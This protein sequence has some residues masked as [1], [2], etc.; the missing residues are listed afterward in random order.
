MS[1]RSYLVPIAVLAFMAT[2]I[3]ISSASTALQD[4][5]PIVISGDGDLTRENGVVSGRGLRQDPYVIEGWYISCGNGTGISIE[6]TDDHLVIRDV[7]LRS[8]GLDA[9]AGVV[10][11]RLSNCTIDNLSIDGMRYG[12]RA[13]SVDSLSI[14]SVVIGNCTYGMTGYWCYGTMVRG[15]RVYD[16]SVG[17]TLGSGED[18]VV[19][20]CVVEAGTGIILGEYSYRNSKSFM[21]LNTTV[22]G[23]FRSIDLRNTDDALVEGCTV[24]NPRWENLRLFYTHGTVVR[25]NVLDLG[26]IMVE[27]YPQ[28]PNI[29]GSN[30]VG[31]LPIRYLKGVKDAVVDAPSGQMVLVDCENVTVANQSFEGALNPIRMHWCNNITV[32]NGTMTDAYRGLVLYDCSDF[33]L[34]GIRMNSSGTERRLVQGISIVR[35]AG[36]IE[37]CLVGGGY[38]EGLGVYG[39]AS[40][41]I[42]NSTIRDFESVGVRLV[43]ERW[44]WDVYG[45]GILYMDRCAVVGNAVGI[46]SDRWRISVSRSTFDDNSGTAID[47]LSSDEVVVTGCVFRNNGVSISVDS[48]VMG[49][50]RDNVLSGHSGIGI[51]VI[52]S[53]VPV[54]DNNITGLDA[55]I[56]VD[57]TMEP[58]IDGN[59]VTGAHGPGIEVRSSSGGG[60]SRCEVFGCTVGVM[61]NGSQDMTVDR[62]TVVGGG[63]GFVFGGASNVT[64]WNCTARW[65]VGEGIVVR[66]ST[67]LLFHHNNLVGNNMDRSTG[68]RYGPQALDVDGG[69]NQWDDG[70]E[71]N[72]WTDMR[73]RYPDARVL[74]GRTWNMSYEVPDDGEDRYPLNRFR[75]FMPPTVDAGEDRTV[76]QGTTV[77]L[78][79][80]GTTDNVRPWY[81]VWSVWYRSENYTMAGAV[82]SFTFNVPGR[83]MITLR[84]WD[85]ARNEGRDNV[86]ITVLD[87]EHPIAD[88]GNGIKV[89][90]GQDFYLVGSRSTDNVGIVSYRWTVDPD[91]AHIVLEGEVVVL[92]LDSYGSHLVVLEVADAA[93][94]RDS[95]SITVRVVDTSPPYADAG[96]DIHAAMG[97]MVTFNGSR[98]WDNTGITEWLWTVKTEQ[99]TVVLTGVAPTHYFDLPG[100]FRVFLRVSDADGNMAYDGLTVI[101]VDPEPPV[102]DAG[103]DLVVGNGEEVLLDGGA[104]RDN[105]RIQSYLWEV[106]NGTWTVH[107]EGLRVPMVFE[108]VGLYRVTLRVTDLDGNWDE[109]ILNVTVHDISPPVARAGRD[110]KVPQGTLV[111]LD[112]SSSTDNV[113][114]AI[115]NWTVFTGHDVIVLDG[116]VVS[117]VF[118]TPG[119]FHATLQVTDVNELTDSDR[120]TIDVMDTE[121]PHANAGE[122]AMA[123]LRT[124]VTLDGRLSTDNGVIADYQWK[125][126]YMGDERVFHGAVVRF[127]FDELGEYDIELRVTD[128]DGN[129]D[130]DDLV[131]R[132]L[133][134]ELSVYIGPFKDLNTD[135]VS[136]V[137]VSVILNG[138]TYLGITDGTGWMFVQVPTGE[139]GPHVDVNASKDGYYPLSFR[140]RLDRWGAPLGEVPPMER[141]PEPDPERNGSTDI[142]TIVIVLV[143]ALTVVSC[144]SLRLKARS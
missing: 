48:S 134:S 69:G 104:S 107:R 84:V 1:V 24:R 37:D 87:T 112:G 102:A 126:V 101:V 75:D 29:D 35:G 52:A 33:V 140:M 113:G 129:G 28:N 103:E 116:L 131:V 141:V 8:T 59:I 89:K 77:R 106:S 71:G 96:P 17:M 51:E 23:D 105:Y 5:D 133:P 31:G 40:I 130:S 56:L 26:G 36:R 90:P 137:H 9:D 19:R 74:N 58:E 13:Y 16:C 79:G 85:E 123:V 127:A 25:N 86:W 43:P 92:S 39:Q 94:N 73:K 53:K 144:A 2:V 118:G 32:V 110:V 30:T 14:E 114:I 124:T 81:F 10:L 49:L 76:G 64:M 122:D 47:C 138:T 27:G 142:L 54:V 82:S 125:F 128:S 63:H 21:L 95:D 41:E 18:L 55:A 44:D 139:L 57:R 93:G 98:C 42:S 22:K 143:L 117:Y 60:V 72:Y 100:V 108:G 11:T 6:G 99:Q 109:D 78:D 132:V 97:T 46:Y 67:G 66:G 38:S 115:A 119:A 34:S 135:P 80:S 20:D 15:V 111:M 12:I 68:Y 50:I 88:A 83:Y 61:V 45:G 70:S 91:G 7:T 65:C 4:H 136:G 62:I 3:A 120:V 121:D